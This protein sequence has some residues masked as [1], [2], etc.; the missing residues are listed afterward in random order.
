MQQLRKAKN[1]NERN[2]MIGKWWAVLSF[3]DKSEVYVGIGMWRA[4]ENLDPGT[5]Y[6]NGS[7]REQAVERCKRGIDDMMFLQQNFTKKKR[8]A[9][10]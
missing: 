1:S 10:T 4:A 8:K 5:H 6:G 9:A 7:T 2:H 3:A